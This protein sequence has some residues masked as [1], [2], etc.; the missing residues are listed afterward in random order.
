MHFVETTEISAHE[1]TYFN[2]I[3]YI[4]APVISYLS[5]YYASTS[6]ASWLYIKHRTSIKALYFYI[7]LYLTIMVGSLSCLLTSCFFLNL[8]YKLIY[9]L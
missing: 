1:S 3:V 5:V 4:I 2:S 9:L 6:T 8:I 7:N